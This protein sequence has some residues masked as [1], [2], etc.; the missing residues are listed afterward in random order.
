MKRG[1]GYLGDRFKAGDAEVGLDAAVEAQEFAPEVGG[2]EV[3]VGQQGFGSRARLAVSL[4][5]SLLKAQEA[6]R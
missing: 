1:E 4:K 5:S 6:T 3:G 2:G